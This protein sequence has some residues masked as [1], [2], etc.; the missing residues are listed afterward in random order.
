MEEEGG[1]EMLMKIKER[2][3]VGEKGRREEGKTC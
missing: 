2:G 1:R 3:M